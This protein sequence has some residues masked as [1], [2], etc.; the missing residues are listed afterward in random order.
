VADRVVVQDADGAVRPAEAEIASG[1]WWPDNWITP[2]LE[3]RLRGLPGVEAV[4]VSGFMPALAP[5]QIDN[6]IVLRAG[7]ASVARQLE[8]GKSFELSLPLAS[9]TGDTMEIRMEIDHAIIPDGFDARERGVIVTR[10]ALRRA[11]G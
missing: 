10:V 2:V 7:G 6:R 1:K 4:Q 5:R 9:P 11:G 3:L 8:W